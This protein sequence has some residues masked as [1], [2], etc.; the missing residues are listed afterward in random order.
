MRK[1]PL[2]VSLGAALVSIV[3]LAGCSGS[4]DAANSDAVDEVVQDDA[5]DGE[6]EA[7]SETVESDESDADTESAEE[8]TEAESAAEPE[9]AP[10]ITFD[11][12]VSE[13]A[14][15]FRG[16]DFPR[17]PGGESCA[18]EI[19]VE[20]M[21]GAVDTITGNV[22]ELADVMDIYEREDARGGFIALPGEPGMRASFECLD[23]G[24]LLSQETLIEDP[25]RIECFLRELGD[26][27]EWVMRYEITGISPGF[28][29][30]GLPPEARLMEVINRFECPYEI[31]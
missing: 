6:S 14:E 5:S 22:I 17:W 16:R 2:S 4:N 31:E 27:F 8:T 30:D 24:V 23:P 20:A 9:A 29:G 1:S 7:P 3:A 12:V 25:E 28:D 18:A 19:F 26:D 15:W 10:E 21:V 11:D 13:L